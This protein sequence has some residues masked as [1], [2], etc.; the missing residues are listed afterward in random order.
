MV[1]P[2]K[3]RKEIYNAPKHKRRKMVSSH[4]S[5][6]LVEKYG[7]RSLPVRKGDTVKIIRGLWKG[8]EGKVSSVDL[9][10][11]AISVEGVLISKADKKQVPRWIHASNVI[12]TKLDLSDK[13][14]YER[15]K[16]IA[17]LK[18]KVIEEGENVEQTPQEI[19]PQ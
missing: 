12:I 2:G 18:N 8:T 11:M 1:K 13:V 9:K 6:E 16:N 7:I 14:R 19:K 17:K 15:L 3:V 10:K 5:D 4:L